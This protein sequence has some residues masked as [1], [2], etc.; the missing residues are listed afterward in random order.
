MK[1]K[2]IKKGNIQKI[3]DLLLV[4][5][6]IFQDA[7]DFKILPVDLFKMFITCLF[8]YYVWDIY[9]NRT[10]PKIKKKVFWVLIYI[11]IVTVGHRFNI[12]TIKSVTFL[13]VEFFTLYMYVSKLKN[14]SRVYKI[15]YISAFI[16]SVYGIIQYVSFKINIP[17]IYDITLYGFRRNADYLALG[18]PHSIYSEPAHLCAILSA[19]IYIGLLNRDN[20]KDYAFISWPK[21]ITIFVFA[22]LTQSVLVYISLIAYIVYYWTGNNTIIIPKK[23]ILV[24]IIVVII[25]GFLYGTGVIGMAINKIHY[26]FNP[27]ATNMAGQTG[28]ALVSNT[29]I[30]IEKL[31]DFHIFGT[32]IYSHEIYYY[33]Y[34]NRLYGVI[35]HY[36]NY[37]DA[38]SLFIRVFSEFGLIGFAYFMVFIIKRIMLYFKSNKD[39]SFFII[40][41]IV[42]GMRI[43]HYTNVLIL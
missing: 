3:I 36:V 27:S 15:L 26:I 11:F 13:I 20:K 40:L 32:G 37:Q 14:Y 39:L 42:E 8:V 30:A 28:F 2:K 24:P 12:S 31:K 29:R 6:I 21:T 33:E 1:L 16:L 7:G 19:A 43:G 23:K 4:L 9:K 10:I 38:A 34:I 5:S 25:V 35:P 17:N 18:R 22:M 41:L